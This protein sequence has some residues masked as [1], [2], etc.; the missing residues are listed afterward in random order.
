MQ[1][2]S[3]VVGTAL[4]FPSV[5]GILSSLCC[6]LCLGEQKPGVEE[7]LWRKALWNLV[8]IEAI[9]SQQISLSRAVK[10]GSCSSDLQGEL[11]S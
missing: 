2:C 1:H 3:G 5:Q 10:L 9:M 7:G 6:H 11:L 4:S 8:S